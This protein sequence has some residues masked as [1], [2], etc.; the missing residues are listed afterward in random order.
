MQLQIETWE[1]KLS[2]LFGDEVPDRVKWD[3]PDE[4]AAFF[5]AMHDKDAHIFLPSGGGDE[6]QSYRVNADGLL[7]WSGSTST[8]T[9]MRP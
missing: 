4:I 2:A 3:T 1:E 6:I 5:A 8:W 9:A 7:E